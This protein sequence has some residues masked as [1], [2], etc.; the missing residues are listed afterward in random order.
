MNHAD[1][2]GT[3]FQFSHLH[4]KFFVFKTNAKF[5]ESDSEIH[6]EGNL[7][8]LPFSNQNFNSSVKLCAFEHIYFFVHTQM[9]FLQTE[10]TKLKSGRHILENHYFKF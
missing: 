5:N 8:Q 4:G 7:S 6:Y 1:E 3:N 2:Q 10:S 9:H